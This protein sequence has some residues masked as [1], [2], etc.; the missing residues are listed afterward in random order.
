MNKNISFSEIVN[1][2]SEVLNDANLLHDYNE[3]S[4]VFEGVCGWCGAM[5]PLSRVAF[6]Q[7]FGAETVEK[8]EAEARK[9]IE[10]ENKA[11][12]ATGFHAHELEANKHIEDGCKAPEKAGQFVWGICS[13]MK[14]E[15]GFSGELEKLEID[16]LENQKRSHRLCCIEK[17]VRV[18]TLPMNAAEC[19]A[20]VEKHGLNGGSR[21]DDIESDRNIWQLTKK[22]IG[23]F[24]TVAAAIVDAAGRWY[25]ID[26]EGYNYCRYFYCPLTYREVFAKE[27]EAIRDRLAKEKA[28]QEKAEQEAAAARF[29]EYQAK[30]AKW[31]GLMEPVEKYEQEAKKTYSALN[32]LP[33]GEQKGSKEQKANRSA[34][35]KLY[36]V[37]RRNIV[38]MVKAAFPGLSFS[39][40]KND[41][42]GADWCIS[43]EDGPTE[44]DFKK[45]TDLDLFATYGDRFDG[46][47]DSSYS[48]HYEFTEFASKYMGA[49]SGEIE[50][51]RDWSDDI[52]KELTA[53]HN[54]NWSD[55][56]YE[57]QHT[58]YYVAPV[59]S[60][61][62]DQKETPAENQKKD[63]GTE[64]AKGLELV[65]I[66]GGVAV[67]GDCK[68]TYRNR[69]EI[70]AHGAKW[71]R[72]AQQWQATD[73][74]DIATLRAWF[75]ISL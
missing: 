74:A 38:A 25:L 21:C 15:S 73:P 27:L 35:A 66:A 59:A 9:A 13:G 50:I 43:W 36:H 7:E 26:A 1:R 28:E 71:N 70:K 34:E 42:W 46:Y 57:F 62:Q 69:K 67:V 3:E 45:A 44:E 47:T 4:A 18:D 54:G 63:D 60:E 22:E 11:F 68:T 19:D 41:G 17:V 5:A 30:C 51:C 12:Q 31:S 10:A 49:R 65:E 6:V 23:L 64:P 39:V 56:K 33:Y 72:D 40:K 52:H 14:G 58:G 8:A 55:A 16:E 24:Y 2:L 53:K 29:A 48:E 20:M 32:A 37:R 75:A 61:E